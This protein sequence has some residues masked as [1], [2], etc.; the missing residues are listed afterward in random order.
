MASIAVV[1]AIPSE[2]QTSFFWRSHIAKTCRENASC[3]TW[4]NFSKWFLYYIYNK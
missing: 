2:I 4:Q 1:L 3:I